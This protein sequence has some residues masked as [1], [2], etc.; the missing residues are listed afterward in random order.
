MLCKVE[1]LLFKPILTTS[2]FY[3]MWYP[4]TLI[5]KLLQQMNVAAATHIYICKQYQ[6]HESSFT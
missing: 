5:A 4:V 6:A 2:T 3:E 1:R